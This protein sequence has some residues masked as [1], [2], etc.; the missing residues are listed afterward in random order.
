M[1]FLTPAWTK[2]TSRSEQRRP[3]NREL[4]QTAAAISV[5]RRF[6]SLSAAAAAELIRSARLRC[7]V[8]DRRARELILVLR[9]ADEIDWE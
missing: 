6:K 1:A 7:D 8:G 5:L 4:Q 9:Q 2:T 3:P